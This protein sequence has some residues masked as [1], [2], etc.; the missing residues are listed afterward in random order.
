MHDLPEE[1]PKML[2]NSNVVE[3][4]KEKYDYIILNM[5]YTECFWD[6]IYKN[7][8]PAIYISPNEMVPPHSGRIGAPEFSSVY[9]HKFLPLSYPLTFKGR[10]LS[11]LGN[12][13]MSVTIEAVSRRIEKICRE[14]GIWS[15]D[16]P[17]VSELGKHISLSIVNSIRPLESPVKAI[18]PN[19]IYAG[20]IHIK[21]NNSLPQDIEEWLNGSGDSGFILFSLG[22]AIKPQ[23]MK[24][25]TLD[26][27]LKVFGKLEQ[28]IICS[29]DS[30]GIENIPSNV[31]LRPFLPQ[32]DILAHPKIRL[33]ITHGGI[34]SIQEATYYGVPI[35]GIPVFADQKGNI[36]DT[37][38]QGWGRIV[39]WTDFDRTKI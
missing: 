22:T 30:K 29:W 39:S 18:P 4:L 33:Y 8:V 15:K 1:C 5:F 11:S 21:Q 7:K 38:F 17:P 31:M 27:F 9:P 23:N 35:V 25:E 3:V 12:L 28:R 14:R 32:Q 19:I 26:I 37:V 6:Y 16:T 24:K 20:G 13:Y 36:E 34:L 10:V 2:E